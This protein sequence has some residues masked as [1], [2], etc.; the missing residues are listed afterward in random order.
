MEPYKSFESSLC[1]KADNSCISTGSFSND[2]KY[3]ATAG[4]SGEAKVWNV[5]SCQ[6]HM[7]LFGH[8]DR[9]IDIQFS[10]KENDNLW[11]ASSSADNTI[12]L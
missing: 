1:Q 11:I 5:P 6:L 9:V 12:R 7:N 8:M 10:P 2:G 3:Y 4:W